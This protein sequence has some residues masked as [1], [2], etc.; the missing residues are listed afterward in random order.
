M[1][2]QPMTG[3]TVMITGGAQ[4]IGRA[5]A[6]SFSAVGAAVV[7][8][9]RNAQTARETVDALRASGGEA[10][11]VVAD[12]TDPEQVSRAFDEA[13]AGIGELDFFVNNAGFLRSGP[14]LT[15]TPADWDD[16]FAINARAGFLCVQRAANLMIEQGRGGSIVV[17][18]SNCARTP[19]M[20]LGAYCASKAAADMMTRCFAFELAPHDIRINSLCPGSC[21]TP[22]Q[23]EQ[24]RALGIGPEQQIEGNPSKFRAGIPMGRLAMPADVAAMALMLCAP[25]SAFVTGQSIAV[26]GGQTMS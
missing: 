25:T 11:D 12:L 24:W 18:S 13:V 14:L 7:V 19:R 22:L 20:D 9:D 17:V 4:G 5:I 23:R 2:E 21:D 15:A 1:T 26:D 6:E 10:L 3:K 16:H 8:V